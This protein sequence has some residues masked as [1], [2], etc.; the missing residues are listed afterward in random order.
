MIGLS[1]GH[2]IAAT[3]AVQGSAATA[4]ADFDDLEL[5]NLNRVPAAVFDIGVNKATAA[6]RRIAEIDHISM[7][8]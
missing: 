4:S 5:S 7:S 6:A 8:G 1:V 2:A 3:L